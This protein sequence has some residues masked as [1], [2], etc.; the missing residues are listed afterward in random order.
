MIHFTYYDQKT[1]DSWLKRLANSAALKSAVRKCS[2]ASATILKGF[3][4][5]WIYCIT[6]RGVAGS[7]KNP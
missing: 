4:I 6:A 5:A 1:S 7:V 2:V 3:L